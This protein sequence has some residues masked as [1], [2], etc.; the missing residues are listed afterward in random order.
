MKWLGGGWRQEKQLGGCI[1][2]G[3]YVMYPN[4]VE[5]EKIEQ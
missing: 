1:N 5:A 3:C 2:L 4:W